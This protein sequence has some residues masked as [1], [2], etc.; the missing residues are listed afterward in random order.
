MSASSLAIDAL[1]RTRR[2]SDVVISA[3]DRRWARISTFSSR[4]MFQPPWMARRSIDVSLREDHFD[5]LGWLI[6][7][8]STVCALAGIVPT[9]LDWLG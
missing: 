2:R 6:G 4:G 5:R 1:I 8:V 7:V 3:T 9:T